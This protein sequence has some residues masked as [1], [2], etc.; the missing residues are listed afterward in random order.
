[1]NVPVLSDTSGNGQV[2]LVFPPLVETNFGSYYPSTAVLSGHLKSRGIQTAQFDLNEE[3]AVYMLEPGRLHPMGKGDFGHGIKQ[4][5]ASMAPVAARVLERFG[6]LLTDEHGRHLFREDATEAS[7]L[8]NMLVKPLRIDAPIDDITSPDIFGSPL[9]RFYDDFYTTTSISQRLPGNTA[10]AGIS[11]PAGPQL[12]PAL[13]LAR[14]LKQARPEV[15]IALGGPA[16]SLLANSDIR[17]ILNTCSDVDVTVISDGEHPLESLSTQAFSRSWRPETVAG[18]CCVTPEG[19]CCNPP[20]PGPDLKQ[21]AFADYDPV[22][23]SKIANP[24]IGIIQARGCYWGKC[25]YCDYVEIYRANPGYRSRTP[26]AFVNELEHQFKTHS[27][28][29]FSVITEAI[30]PVFAQKISQL[31]LE[32]KLKVTWHSFASADINFTVDT[33]K[34]MAKAGCEFLAV[35]IETM[36]DRVL[37]L[38]NKASSRQ[39]NIDFLKRAKLAGLDIKINL[40][41]DLPS[42]TWKESMETLEVIKNLEGCYTYISYFPFEATCTSRVG[43][44]PERF[45]LKPVKAHTFSGQAQFCL[46]HL[47][48]EDPAMNQAEKQK[49]VAEYQAFAAKVNTSPRYTDAPDQTDEQPQPDPEVLRFKLASDNLDIYPAGA[50]IQCYNWITRTR[51][52][53]PAEWASALKQMQNA[54]SFSPDEF[55][56]WSPPGTPA[57]FLLDKLREKGILNVCNA[58]NNIE[59]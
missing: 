13:V 9:F 8:L 55:Y 53:V 21:L 6:H 33:M 22:I 24:E 34:L 30:P 28:N 20:Q 12:G 19:F 4:D 52:E 5:P 57:D 10:L 27:V 50:R 35:G 15:K 54:E 48:V 23:L 7:Y 18:T 36:N 43:K 32:R 51:F 56:E 38:M 31:I 11:V 58:T 44:N 37:K 40:I 47:E 42:T 26:E 45:G 17:R 14:H 39:D 49:L 1:M 46:N 25:A 29:R 16:L 3:F 2:A 59:K 41:P